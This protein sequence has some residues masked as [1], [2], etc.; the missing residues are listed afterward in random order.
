MPFFRSGQRSTQSRRVITEPG[1]F[2]RTDSPASMMLPSHSDIMIDRRERSNFGRPSKLRRLSNIFT[3]WRRGVSSQRGK[4]ILVPS[5]N[6]QCKR[7]DVRPLGNRRGEASEDGLEMVLHQYELQNRPSQRPSSKASITAL[8]SK[9]FGIGSSIDE[10][11]TSPLDLQPT[12]RGYEVQDPFA[13]DARRVE[14]SHLDLAEYLPSIPEQQENLAHALSID[15]ALPLRVSKSSPSL[16]RRLSSQFRHPSFIHQPSLRPK[17]SI[18]SGHYRVDSAAIQHARSSQGSATTNF[19]S[20][21]S[22]SPARTHS[23]ALTSVGSFQSNTRGLSESSHHRSI[24]AGTVIVAPSR[25][26]WLPAIRKTKSGGHLDSCTGIPSISTIERAIA[27]KTFLEIHFARLMDTEPTPRSLRRRGLEQQLIGSATTVEQ[28]EELR[29]KLQASESAYVRDLR[30]QKAKS[31]GQ[32]TRKVMIGDYEIV[33]VLGK[34][35]FGVVR[36]VRDKNPDVGPVKDREPAHHR[37]SNHK[38]VYAMKVIRKSEMIRTAQEGHLRAERD[39]LVKAATRCSRWIV[40]LFASFQDVDH[41]YLVMEY[42]SGGDF[43][44]LLIRKNTLPEDHTRWYLAEMILGVSEAHA[45]GCIHRDIKP[46]NFMVSSSGH[47]KLADF[48]LAFDGHWSHSQAYYNDHRAQM[49]EQFGIDVKGDERDQEEDLLAK[50]SQEA[51]D[52]KNR[53]KRT[54]KGL[55]GRENGNPSKERRD[56]GVSFSCAGGDAPEIKPLDHYNGHCMRSLAVSTVGT[57]Q[58]M[59]PEVIQ[60]NEKYDGRCDYWSIGIIAYE[61]HYGYTP[62]YSEDRQ[63]TKERILDWKA[64]LQFPPECLTSRDLLR[65]LRALLT[66]KEKRLSCKQYALNDAVAVASSKHKLLG[67]ETDNGLHA[68]S[69]RRHSSPQRATPS[70]PS[71][72]DADA[73]LT[74]SP[75]NPPAPQFLPPSTPDDASALKSHPFFRGVPWTRMHRTAPP[76]IPR[77]RRPDDARYFGDDEMTL[78]LAQVEARSSD[79]SADRKMREEARVLCAERGIL[80]EEQEEQGGVG[81]DGVVD[82]GGGMVQEKKGKVR[83]KDRMLRDREAGPVV[84]AERKKGAFLGYTWRSPR[85]EARGGRLFDM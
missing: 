69:A 5:R 24:S 80:E 19:V 84:M 42:M 65:L 14:E 23:T 32:G 45:L 44:S 59:A 27:T 55:A 79:G 38:S 63:Q 15:T 33:Q 20:D 74:D 75:H 2:H 35:S 34:G 53:K 77:V 48:G 47:L 36:L 3:S 60:S 10:T 57:S 29:R 83:A 6:R 61:C 56:S 76:W 37:Q 26:S 62:F 70:N 71:S 8:K 41:L 72:T 4:F 67:V 12:E 25:S 13:A 1:V 52:K 46:E 64:N 7:A 82:V 73:D 22:T 50:I 68:G 16:L 51:E 9:I 43:L 18:E 66:T 11:I 85:K 78:M 28:R 21:F 58:Y 81:L 49:V 40:P 30:A 39:L 54:L 17:P 31:V